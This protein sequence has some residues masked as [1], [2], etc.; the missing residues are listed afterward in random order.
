MKK[1]EIAAGLRAFGLILVFTQLIGCAMYQ[2]NLPAN[3]AENTI[4]C[5][6]NSEFKTSGKCQELVSEPK[7]RDWSKILATASKISNETR[8]KLDANTSNDS[9]FKRYSFVE[10]I[11]HNDTHRVL[12]NQLLQPISGKSNLDIELSISKLQDYFTDIW[13]ATQVNAWRDHYE[14]YHSKKDTYIKDLILT[15]S[16]RGDVAVLE[17]IGKFLTEYLKAYFR[18]AQFMRVALNPERAKERIKEQLKEAMPTIPDDKI[19]ETWESLEKLIPRQDGNYL[20]YSR[21]SDVAFRSRGGADYGFPTI[22]LTLTPFGD[23]PIDL[24]KIDFLGI[25]TDVLRVFIEASGDALLKLPGDPTSTACKKNLLKPFVSNE[26]ADPTD[27]GKSITS[28]QFN[29]VNEIANSADAGVGV[30]TSQIIRGL[31][32]TSLNNEAVAK[33]IET[34]LAGISRKVTEKM[35]WCAFSCYE[36]SGT[37]G[38]TAEEAERKVLSSLLLS[39]RRIII[40]N[41]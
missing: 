21:V 2:F 30:A 29:T 38:V 3:Y 34:L 33:M 6:T 19:N 18:G 22:T 28:K 13:T 40:Y 15:Q 12:M 5:I 16:E 37:P 14:F 9:S 20:L 17:D 41:R 1:I 10:K 11:L 27:S 36:A 31:G 26:K 24:T 35:A 32:W 7:M 23:K 8:K 39:Q 25:G 4:A